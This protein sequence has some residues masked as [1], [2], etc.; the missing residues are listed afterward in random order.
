MVSHLPTFSNEAEQRSY[1]PKEQ[2]SNQLRPPNNG[3]EP[4]Q[5]ISQQYN[6]FKTIQDNERPSEGG[7]DDEYHQPRPS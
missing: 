4:I 6:T 3:S 2:T 5:S 1:N 7:F